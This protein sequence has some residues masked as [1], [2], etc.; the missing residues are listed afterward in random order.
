MKEIIR[1]AE[2]VYQHD[3]EGDRAKIARALII[4][5]R[6]ANELYA[7]LDGVLTHTQ[8]LDTEAVRRARKALSEHRNGRL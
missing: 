8:F 3:K 1:L 4:E 6:R 2:D 5:H 7:A